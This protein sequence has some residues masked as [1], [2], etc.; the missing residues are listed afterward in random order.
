MGSNRE[1]KLLSVVFALETFSALLV[2]LY[3][4]CSNGSSAVSLHVEEVYSIQFTTPAKVGATTVT[5]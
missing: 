2:W 4:D 3:S 5:L 1:R